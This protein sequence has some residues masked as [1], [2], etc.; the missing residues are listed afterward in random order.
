M[1]K[2]EKPVGPLDCT[3]PGCLLGTGDAPQQQLLYAS[4][5]LTCTSQ[6]ELLREPCKVAA[7]QVWLDAICVWIQKTGLA[8]AAM[9]ATLKQVINEGG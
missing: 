9:F 1:L 2:R 7:M 8:A 5:S 6:L 4:S 3:Q